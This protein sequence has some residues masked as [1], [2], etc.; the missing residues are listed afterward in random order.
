[1]RFLRFNVISN[2]ARRRAHFSDARARGMSLPEVLISLTITAMLL[3]A[4]AAAYAASSS[5]ISINDRFYRASQAARVSMAQILNMVRRCDSCQVGG[6]Y[7]GVSTTVSA[8]Y[9]GIIYKDQMT[10]A[11]RNATYQLAASPTNQLQLVQ[12]SQTHPLAHN[13][14]GLTFTADMAPDPGSA[15]GAKVPVSITVDMTVTIGTEKIH[16]RGSAVPR[17]IIVYK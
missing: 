7:D 11:T 8:S 6:T 12:D 16:V 9:I 17:H 3:S 4:V 2:V 10:G 5:A 1:M 13:I 15:S 14:T